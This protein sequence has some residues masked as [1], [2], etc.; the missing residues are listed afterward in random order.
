MISL[1]GPPTYVLYIP[2]LAASTAL[3]C[4]SWRLNVVIFCAQVVVI[5]SECW[6]APGLSASPLRKSPPLSKFFLV[7]GG[8]DICARFKSSLSRVAA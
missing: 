8:C 1:D 2:N 7:F 3:P 5:I 4:A 6:T